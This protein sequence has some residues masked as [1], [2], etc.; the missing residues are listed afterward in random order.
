MTGL[1]LKAY[2]KPLQNSKLHVSTTLNIPMRLSRARKVQ[3]KEAQVPK[4]KK[5]KGGK[6]KPA[7]KK[8]RKPAAAK[9]V[10]T[11]TEGEQQ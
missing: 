8:R 9:P 11:V 10:A 1:L 5:R 7:K 2:V 6:R 4:G 3:A